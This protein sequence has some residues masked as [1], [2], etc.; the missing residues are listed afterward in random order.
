MAL[1]QPERGKVKDAIGTFQ[2]R[3][4]N[5]R[6]HNVAA[7]IIDFDARILQCVLKIFST[8]AYKVVVD[9]DF[10]GVFPNKVLD[11]MG[12]DRTGTTD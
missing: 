5:V 11:G 9:Q 1:Q 6:L 12:T 2:S 3:L 4:Q 8:T 7:D 10:L